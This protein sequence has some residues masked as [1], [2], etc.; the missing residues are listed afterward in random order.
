MPPFSM[1]L[2]PVVSIPEYPPS[3]AECD[4]AEK[5]KY[6]L[7]LTCFWELQDFPRILHN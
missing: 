2:F 4:S 5:G 7:E 3:C 1:F 6:L